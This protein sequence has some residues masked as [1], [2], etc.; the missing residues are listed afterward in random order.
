MI[1][2]SLSSL[3]C[4]ICIVIS[5]RVFNFYFFF[6]FFKFFCSYIRR[7]Y[8][9]YLTFRCFNIVFRCL[10]FH[11]K[12]NISRYFLTFCWISSCIDSSVERCTFPTVVIFCNNYTRPFFTSC[13]ASFSC[14]FNRSS[15]LIFRNRTL[16]TSNCTINDISYR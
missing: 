14:H 10:I 3:T 9:A 7:I 16:S 2:Y 4:K 8:Y 15:F 11:Y 12:F 5:L 13:K 1:I 6:D